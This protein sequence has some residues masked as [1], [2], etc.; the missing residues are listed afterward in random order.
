MGKP[1]WFGYAGKVASMNPATLAALQQ[2]RDKKRN[3]T[4][5]LHKLRNYVNRLPRQ[6][7]VGNSSWNLRNDLTTMLNELENY[8]HFKPLT[9]IDP[10]RIKEILPRMFTPSQLDALATNRELKGLKRAGRQYTPLIL[11]SGLIIGLVI[12]AIIAIMMLK[13][14]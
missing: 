8:L 2:I 14:G 7:V 10:T 12:I 9:I 1:V 11:G 6:L 4:E 5:H 3:A 13:G